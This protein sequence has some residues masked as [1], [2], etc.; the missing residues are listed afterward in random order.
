MG[1]VDIQNINDV[2]TKREQAKALLEEELMSVD[3]GKGKT[4]HSIEQIRAARISL[5]RFFP[6]LIGDLQREYNIMITPIMRKQ[7]KEIMQARQ[8]LELKILAYADACR[9]MGEEGATEYQ[10]S[11]KEYQKVQAICLN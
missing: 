7:K 10:S 3:F 8:A 9:D 5:T 11:V 2:M 4:A 6:S 1:A